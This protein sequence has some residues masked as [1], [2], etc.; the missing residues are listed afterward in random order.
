MLDCSEVK[1]NIDIIC[2][3]IYINVFVHI[4]IFLL[5]KA[6]VGSNTEFAVNIVPSKEKNVS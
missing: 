4:R 2:L 5:L 1:M 3:H 6:L